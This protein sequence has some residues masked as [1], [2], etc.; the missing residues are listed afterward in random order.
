MQTPKSNMRL[1]VPLA[2]IF[3]TSS[4]ILFELIY[5]GLWWYYTIIINTIF[6][7]PA[8]PVTLP[9]INV[10]EHTKLRTHIMGAEI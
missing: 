1:L 7:A 4:S 5:R 6:A 9:P 10:M 8:V 2:N 3:G